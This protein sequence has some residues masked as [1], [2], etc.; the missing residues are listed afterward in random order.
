MCPICNCDDRGRDSVSS[1]Q[2][3][4]PI[5]LNPPLKNEKPDP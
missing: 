1:V 5:N 3:P 4:F 2:L